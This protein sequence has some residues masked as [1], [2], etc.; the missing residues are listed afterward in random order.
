MATKLPKKWQSEKNAT[1]AVQVAF[2]LGERVQKAIRQE[3]LDEN[4]SPTDRVREIL[5]LS[6]TRKPQR[7]RLSISLVDEDFKVLAERFGLEEEDRLAIKQRASETIVQ[8]V[9]GEDAN[10]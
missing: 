1:R 9:T 7:L 6:V 4:V 5:G 2:D 8:H 10:G 3:A